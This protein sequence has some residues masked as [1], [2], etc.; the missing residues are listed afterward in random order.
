MRARGAEPTTKF[1]DGEAVGD[2]VSEEWE[3]RPT[4]MPSSESVART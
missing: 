2:Q 1:V 3:G 4:L